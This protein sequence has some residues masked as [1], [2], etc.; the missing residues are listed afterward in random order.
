MAVLDVGH[1]VERLIARAEI[2]D[3]AGTEILVTALTDA[4]G[5]VRHHAAFYLGQVGGPDVVPAL[6]AALNDTQPLVAATAHDSLLVFAARG[7]ARAQTAV[8]GYRGKRF[9]VRMPR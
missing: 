5:F 4:N 6:I 3:P 7:D 8:D 9:D 1:H 2:G